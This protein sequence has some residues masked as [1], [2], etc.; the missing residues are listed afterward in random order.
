MLRLRDLGDTE[1]GAFGVSAADDLLLVE[2]VCLIGQLCSAVTVR[3]FDE[4]V[5]DHFDR[6]VDAGLA[7]ERFARIWIHTHPGNGA[8]PSGTDE[9]TFSEFSRAKKISLRS[10]TTATTF[11]V[12]D[13]RG[14]Q[15]I[16]LN[17]PLRGEQLTLEVVDQYLAE[18]PESPVCITDVVFY[19]GGEP[20]NGAY[21]TP[22]LKYDKAQVTVLGTWY[23]GFQGAPERYLSAKTRK[24]TIEEDKRQLELLKTEF[25]ADTPLADLTASRISEYKAKRL[26]AVRKVGETEQRLSAAPV[27]R[28]LALLRH[29]LRLAHEEWGELAAVPKIA[30]KRSLRAGYAGSQRQKRGLSSTLAGNAGTR[31]WP[32][33]SSSRCSPACV[34]ARRLA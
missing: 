24:R 4:S 5:A 33:S 21:L 31:A 6:Q 25:G 29:L 13:Q 20:L 30:L 1:V 2:D 22:K 9:E 32:T 26:S 12:A 17:P 11:T 16:T 34:G 18:D 15:S 10:P 8:S 14:L 19:S 7:P 28:P 23:A 27:N 3:F